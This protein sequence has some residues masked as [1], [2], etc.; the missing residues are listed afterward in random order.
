MQIHVEIK[1]GWGMHDNMKP[2]CH[3]CEH[4]YV[5]WDAAF[6]YGCRGFQMKSKRN[7]SL[8]VYFASGRKCMLFE[9]RR[10]RGTQGAPRPKHKVLY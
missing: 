5:T 8:S 4:Y 10:R 2:E 7:P 3:G 1:R 6:P 9:K